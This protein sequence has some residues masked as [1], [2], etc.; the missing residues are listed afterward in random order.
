MSAPARR[1]TPST[2]SNAVVAI[3]SLYSEAMA[4]HEA[5]LQAA[6]HQ[7]AFCEQQVV[8]LKEELREAQD[9]AAVLRRERLEGDQVAGVVIRDLKGYLRAGLTLE[10]SFA[11]VRSQYGLSHADAVEG[12]E[13]GALGEG[14]G[15]GPG[16]RGRDTE[17]QEVARACGPEEGEGPQGVREGEVEVRDDDARASSSTDSA[18]V[19][20]GYRFEELSWR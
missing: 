18:S 11:V 13:A 4:E 3:V 2:A 7:L 9:E 8:Y 14:P 19:A 15:D 6:R 16:V 1:V 20:W 10:D 17:G 12:S 5:A